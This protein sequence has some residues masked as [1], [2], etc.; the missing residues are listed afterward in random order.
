M[1]KPQRIFRQQP[2]FAIQ[3]DVVAVIFDFKV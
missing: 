2:S 3:A 1:L